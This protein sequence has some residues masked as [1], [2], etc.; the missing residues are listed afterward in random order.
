MSEYKPAYERALELVL[1]RV[2]TP[3][4][5]G[6][7]VLPRA[8]GR[9]AAETVRAPRPFPPQPLSMLDGVAVATA[10]RAEDGQAVRTGEPVPQWAEDVIPSEL[11]GAGGP[12]NRG[13]GLRPGIVRAGAEYRDGD[14][15][16]EAGQKIDHRHVAQLSLFGI[17]RARVFRRPRIRIAVF[18]SAPFSEALLAWVAG[19]VRSYCDVDLSAERIGALEGMRFLGEETDLGLVLSDGAPG[20]YDEIKGL[21]RG[22]LEGYEPVFWKLGLS[23]PK[24]VGFGVL[25]G[26]P[27]LVFPDVFFKTVLSAMAFLPTV[28]AAWVG[29]RP[30]TRPARW[31]ELPEISYPFPCLVPL[32]FGEK[33]EG[34][35]VAAT[36]LR[37]SF[38]ARWASAAEGYV[39]LERPPRE[40]DELDAVELGELTAE[41]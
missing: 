16:L 28:L 38:S 23:P 25:G 2:A 10:G 17:E 3:G 30:R 36:P 1:E 26:V 35:E 14:P 12:V 32:R 19:F 20:R 4:P 33:R 18:D 34:L 21:E 6:E 27:V 41:A 13:P 8:E 31:A 37:S 39:I 9:I 24:H 29:A 22:E 15:I 7:V 40:D 5:V 11:V